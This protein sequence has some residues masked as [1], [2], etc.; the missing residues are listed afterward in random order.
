M[1]VK[2]VPYGTMPNGDRVEMITLE[3]KAGTQLE[4]IT[5]GGTLVRLLVPDHQGSRADVLL[6]RQALEDYRSG[7]GYL[8]ALIGRYANRIAGGTFAMDGKIYHLG[9]NEGKN[10]LHGGVK[11]FDQKVWKV[12]ALEDGASPQV[13]LSCTAADGEEGFPGNIEVRVTYQL[14]EDNSLSIHYWAKADQKTPI[15]LTNHAY[16]NV[17]G[18]ESG[19]VLD[20]VLWLDADAFTPTDAQSIPTGEILP[21]KGT[22]MDFTTPKAIGQEIHADYE[23]LKLAKG[24]DHNFVLNQQQKGLKRFAEVYDPQTGRAMEVFT[25]LPGVQ[26]YTANF[27]DGSQ[28]GKDGI[29]LAQHDALCLE[30]QFFPDSVN[31]PQ[32]PS[33]FFEAGEEFTTTTVYHFFMK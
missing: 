33:P 10:T 2:T 25:D 8:G 1:A 5:L 4:L 9:Q 31:Q 26:L 6:G 13:V 20:H 14:T 11:G 12:E 16:F 22:P 15:N 32:F 3:N 21:V 18:F 23:Q 7:A 24:Y 27:L 17:A 19:K 30:T 28:M 29:P